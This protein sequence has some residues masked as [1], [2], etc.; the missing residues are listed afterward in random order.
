[1]TPEEMTAAAVEATGLDDFGGDSFR[2]GLDAYCRSIDEAQLNDIGHIAV[3]ANVTA[4]LSNRLKVVDWVKL[5]PEIREEEIVAPVFVIGM[6]RAG[7]T[8]LS[9]L[10]DC[11][12]GNRPLLRW[13]AGD[14]IPPPHQNEF[15]RGPRVDAVAESAAMLDM[16]N[17]DISKVHHETADGPTECLT[18]LG[19]D[20]KSLVWEAITN[21]PSYSGWLMQADSRSA[22]DYHRLALQTLQSGG[23]RGRWTL[24]SPHHAIALDALT[25]VYPDARLVLLHRDPVALC[26]SVCS[27]IRTL[28]KTFS[29]ADHSAYI[30]R[31]WSDLLETSY[32]R[33]GAFRAARPD[34]PLLDVDYADLMADPVGTVSRIYQFTGDPL[35]EP[36]ARAMEA[37]VAANPQ[38]RHGRHE[39]ALA[40]Y[41]LDE[42]EIRERFAPYVG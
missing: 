22:Y 14:S 31:H 8:L 40:D 18:L 20:F 33:I 41:G 11:D 27:L 2:A 32:Q 23:V 12:G 19:Q 34:F 6:F 4:S 17:P 24:K 5:H 3:A 36:A 26:G 30:G 28:S 9:N 15:R 13:E 35:T 10:F 29:D 37:F 21:V 16:L 1:M 38:G 25:A 39:Y 7:T 42:A